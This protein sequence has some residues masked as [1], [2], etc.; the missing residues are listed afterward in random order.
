[1]KSSNFG[2]EDLCRRNAAK[3]PATVTMIEN[4]SSHPMNFLFQLN[5]ITLSKG[6]SGLG[7]SLFVG[8]TRQ[9]LPPVRKG[10]GIAGLKVTRGKD[11]V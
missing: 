8:H 3:M 7:F 11:E 1:L 5:F 2:V 9:I 6:N 10:P 4:R